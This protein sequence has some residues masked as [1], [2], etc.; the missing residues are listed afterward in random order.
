MTNPLFE[1]YDLGDI[2]L[3][4]RIVMAPLTRSRAANGLVPG[5]HAPE[6]YSQRASAGLIITEATQIS[7]QAQGYQ[8]TPGLYTPAQIAG[9]RSVTDAVHEAGGKI[10]VQLWHVGRVSHVDLQPDHAAPVA[11]SAIAAETKTFVNNSFVPVSEPRALELDEIPGIITDFRNAAAD[12]IAAGFDGV[13]IHGANG[14]L[15]DQ[16]ARDGSNHRTDAYGGSIENRARLMIEVATAVADEVGAGRTG[17]RISPV[18]P[19]NGVS[20]SNPQPLFNHIVEQLDALNLAYL[21]VVEGATDGPRDAAPFD[22]DAL[23]QRF[24]N[25]YLANNGYDLDLA[26]SAVAAGKADLVAFG[27]PFIANPDLVARLK[28]GA[29]LAQADQATFYGGGVAGYTDYPTLEKVA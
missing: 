29:P 17:I 20:D 25:T 13:E 8:D 5:P 22:F 9:W 15:L 3:S 11:P 12:A 23:R 10:F 16:F 7:A 19:A 21:H 1:P 18:S 27:R 2:R 6:Y 24:R 28:T 14:Y 26:T 4:N